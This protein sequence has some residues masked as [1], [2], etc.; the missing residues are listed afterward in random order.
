[1]AILSGGLRIMP[2]SGGRVGKGIYFASE[3]HKSASYVRCSGDTGIMFLS[4]V[5]IGKQH[6]IVEDDTSLVQA[7][8]GYDSIIAR[9]HTEP[10]PDE[11]TVIKIDGKDIIVPQGKPIKMPEYQNSSFS[12]SEY[13]VYDESRNRIRFLCK[14]KFDRG[15]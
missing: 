12:E 15:F 1:V 11:D 3:N 6:S 9:G 8:N 13:L 2:H 4:E 10:D 5:V 7:P 14:L